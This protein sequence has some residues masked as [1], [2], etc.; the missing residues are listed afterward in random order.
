MSSNKFKIKYQI[1]FSCGATKFVDLIKAISNLYILNQILF[2]Q[3]TIVSKVIVGNRNDFWSVLFIYR[4]PHK[5]QP[6][7][8]ISILQNFNVNV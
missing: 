8:P 2:V 4:E 1:P 6:P 3:F 5:A 7:W